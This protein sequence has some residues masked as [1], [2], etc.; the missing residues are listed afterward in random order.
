VYSIEDG[1]I[2]IM[3]G[4][5]LIKRK[6]SGKEGRKEGRKE[7]RK[8]E[9]REEGRK[10]IKEGRANPLGQ[11]PNWKNN[12]FIIQRSTGYILNDC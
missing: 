9:G 5:E 4:R 11:R 7:R 8:E 10:E 2:G 6:G 1:A 12:L 3:S